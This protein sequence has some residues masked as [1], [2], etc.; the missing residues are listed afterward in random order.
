MWE[1]M[2]MGG[3]SDGVSGDQE[4]DAAARPQHN[5][6]I[7]LSRENPDKTVLTEEGKFKAVL[8][9]AEWE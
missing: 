1:E 6:L 9:N 4:Q 8:I 7:S 2:L 5:Y 3:V